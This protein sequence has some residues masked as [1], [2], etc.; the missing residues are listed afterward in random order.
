[1]HTDDTS[2]MNESD[3]LRSE[4]VKSAINKIGSTYRYGGRGP[5]DFDCSGF[6]QFTF[7]LNN[8]AISGSAKSISKMASAIDIKDAKPGD[9]I[10]FKKDGHIFHVSIIQKISD[11]SIIVVHSTTSRGVIEEDILASPYWQE[12]IYK[13]ISLESLK[14]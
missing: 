12:K 11:D 8:I 7:G 4:I 3:L 6:V 2:R 14:N 5:N 10:F 9:L 13:V 1:M